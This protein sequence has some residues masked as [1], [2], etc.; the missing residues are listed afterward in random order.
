MTS[1]LFRGHN[2]NP[3]RAHGSG[4]TFGVENDADEKTVQMIERLKGMMGGQAMIPAV[5]DQT[6]NPMGQNGGQNG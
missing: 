2:R 6:Q 3:V 5:Q 1:Y 4:V